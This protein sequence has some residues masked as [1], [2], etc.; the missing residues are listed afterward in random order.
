M[1][2][3]LRKPILIQGTNLTLDTPDAIDA[4]VEER[5]KRWPSSTLIAEKKRKFEQA[6][7][8]GELSVESLGLFSKKKRR[9]QDPY[10]GNERN[11][12]ARGGRARGRGNDWTPRGSSDSGWRGRGARGRGRGSSFGSRG[13]DTIDR[14]PVLECAVSPQVQIHE[15]LKEEKDKDDS[16][17]DSDSEPEILSSKL[18]PVPEKQ[19][20]VSEISSPVPT[21]SKPKMVAKIPRPQPKKP[22]P[23]PF[24]PRTS[25][26]RNVSLASF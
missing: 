22:P 20:K 12:H 10:E 5:K 25:L 6:S 15:P 23:N 4:W 24:A 1:L 14:A 9:V 3:Y 18:P 13:D 19:V 17:S 21:Q 2:G 11:H 16:A 8:R 7:A 26:L